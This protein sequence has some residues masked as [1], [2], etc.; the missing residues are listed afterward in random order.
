MHG[1]VAF[2][3][4]RSEFQVDY[5]VQKNLS[6]E[7]LSEILRRVCTVFKELHYISTLDLSVT[8]WR[9]IHSAFLTLLNEESR[10][11][12]RFGRAEASERSVYSH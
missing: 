2:L 5:G 11:I 7:T 3:Q 12:L 6:L 4:R 8:S 10:T 1:D 9:T